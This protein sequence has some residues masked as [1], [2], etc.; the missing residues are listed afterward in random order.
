MS[1]SIENVKCKSGATN[2]ELQMKSCEHEEEQEGF[3]KIEPKQDQLIF[4]GDPVNLKCRLNLNQTNQTINWYLNNTLITN[5]LL[6]YNIQ[7]RQNSTYSELNVAALIARKH[8]GT[9]TCVAIVNGVHKVKTEIFIKVLRTSS[10]EYDSKTA[11]RCPDTVTVTSK[12]VYMWNKTSDFDQIVE[13]A[14]LNDGNMFASYECRLNSDNKTANWFNLNVT[15]CDYESNL[16]RNLNSLLLTPSNMS[17]NFSLNMTKSNII[18]YHLIIRIIQSRFRYG[19]IQNDYNGRFLIE[20]YNFLSKQPLDDTFMDFNSYEFN[21]SLNTLY[22]ML[23]FYIYSQNS[24]LS[25]PYL[26]LNPPL[27]HYRLSPLLLYYF[28]HFNICSSIISYDHVDTVNASHVKFSLEIDNQRQSDSNELSSLISKQQINWKNVKFL[29]YNNRNADMLTNYELMYS[30]N[31]LILQ[32]WLPYNSKN[33]LQNNF[34]CELE[35]L[36]ENQ[37]IIHIECLFNTHKPQ[38]INFALSISN[39]SENEIK[40]YFYNEKIIYFSSIVSII[41]LL[42]NIIAYLVNYKQILMPSTFK[43]CLINIW[44]NK[45]VQIVANLFFLIQVQVKPLCVMNSLIEQTF[46]ISTFAWYL[47]LIVVLYQKLRKLYRNNLNP[48]K[49]TAALKQSDC[50]TDD[51][52]DAGVPGCGKKKKHKPIMHLYVISIGVPIFLSLLSYT[53]PKY[54]N[55]DFYLNYCFPTQLE[56]LS[57][58][59]MLPIV[60]I[61]VAVFIVSILIL[62][63]YKLMLINLENDEDDVKSAIAGSEIN[64]IN[65][66]LSYQCSTFNESVMDTQ[67][68]PKKQL[69][70]ILIS[71]SSYT[72]IQMVLQMQIFKKYLFNY[73]NFNQIDETLV[74]V[75]SLLLLIYSLFNFSFYFLGRNDTFKR[76]CE[77]FSCRKN[78]NYYFE[79]GDV[80]VNYEKTNTSSASSPSPPISSY[81]DEEEAAAVEESEI[82]SI[83]S[84]AVVNANLCLLNELIEKD[85]AG[86]VSNN[87]QQSVTPSSIHYID[88]AAIN[89][90]TTSNYSFNEQNQSSGGQQKRKTHT[91]N[92]SI[93]SGQFNC[94]QQMLLNSMLVKQTPSPIITT[95]SSAMTNSMSK[96]RAPIYVYVDHT[97]EEKVISKLKSPEISAKKEEPGLNN[98]SNVWLNKFYESDK[99]PFKHETSV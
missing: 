26:A 76:R 34:T 22:Q 38:R 5:K 52:D 67:Y 57:I 68:R 82:K 1:V 96:Q 88:A 93:L 81:K 45:I 54:M 92:G 4:E 8:T 85:D 64:T 91:R 2:E 73:A 7:I 20:F 62:R 65:D 42:V 13:Q 58:T 9:W 72:L 14:C 94:E 44:F 15:Q 16:T 98:N 97:Y 35:S 63:V 66:K 80:K 40:I 12:G 69:L 36:S 86:V 70:L 83:E 90:A 61:L 6:Y 95:L 99:H 84:E 33:P 48:T 27:I 11:I 89:V 28:N 17:L 39:S 32:N 55:F 50:V 23:N 74:Y 53:M 77:I 87:G 21:L 46:I 71:L 51:E 18:D 49:T 60:V 10:V 25:T 41:V 29:N 31:S 43:H 78:R 37:S 30:Q 19:S 3:M 59:F 56:N 75:Y 24:T 79:Q 47:V